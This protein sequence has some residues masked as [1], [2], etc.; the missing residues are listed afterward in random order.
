[1]TMLFLIECDDYFSVKLTNFTKDDRVSFGRV[2][3]AG[4]KAADILVN[5][6]KRYKLGIRPI[7]LTTEDFKND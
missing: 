2:T 7:K 3:I 6:Y 1:M 5:G 4:V